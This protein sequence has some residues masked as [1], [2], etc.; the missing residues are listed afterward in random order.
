[1]PK[2]VAPA[3]PVSKISAQVGGDFW[4]GIPG[5]G[6]VLGKMKS[7]SHRLVGSKKGMKYYPFISK[8]FFTSHHFSQPG[9]Y[10]NQPVFRRSPN[11]VD[12]LNPE[13]IPWDEFHHIPPAYW[14]NMIGTVSSRIQQSQ[15]LGP[16]EVRAAHQKN[17]KKSP[18]VD[19]G[20]FCLEVV[21][22]HHPK[23]GV[24]NP[25]D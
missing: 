13:S 6:L 11:F 7:K 14:G 8:H 23:T 10:L 2:A 24:S 17:E 16:K 1:M 3:S 4:G 12:D 18:Q 25:I 19:H 22:V 21:N 9:T 5:P 15:I 20:F